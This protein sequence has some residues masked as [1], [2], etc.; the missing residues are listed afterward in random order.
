MIIAKQTNGAYISPKQHVIPK[1]KLTKGASQF[2]MCSNI[3]SV[4]T[5]FTNL[6]ENRLC[7]GILFSCKKKLL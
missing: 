2:Q 1:H 3:F 5:A 6:F 7:K 4:Y